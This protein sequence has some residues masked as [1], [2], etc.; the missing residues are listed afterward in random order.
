[1]IVVRSQAVSVGH[2]EVTL[3]TV[4]REKSLMVLLTMMTVMTLMVLLTMMH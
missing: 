1:M 3:D 2:K 4:E